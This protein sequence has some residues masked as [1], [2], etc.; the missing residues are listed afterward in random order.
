MP[1]KPTT[2]VNP[3]ELKNLS[4]D[5]LQQLAG[6][7]RRFLIDSVSKTGGHIGAN[8]GTVE[9]TLALHYVFDSPRDKLI[10]D[11][12][13]QGYTHKV[14]SGRADLFSSLN[15]YGG[16]NRFVSRSESR[17]D[18]I[19]ASHAGT[20]LSVGMGLA[21]ANRLQKK[22]HYVIPIIGD[23]ALCEGMALEA[24][25]HLGA[26]RDL[27]LIVLLNDNGFAISPGY[28]AL[29]DYLQSRQLNSRDPETLFTSLGFHYIGPVDGHDL[30]T[31]V[32]ALQQARD[33][34]RVP[35]VHAKTVKGK[36]LEAADSHPYRM[37]F[38]FP[39]DPQTG[40]AMESSGSSSVGY[41][42]VASAVIER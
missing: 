27:K 22:D 36:G 4:L 35:L 33:S 39:F 34:H 7:V 37:H 1:D 23:G 17:H 12:G 31:L 16:M 6:E 38:S 29:H 11:T 42:D 14:V 20:S 3:Q 5:E 15:T 24:L 9:L 18:I 32:Q 28:G 21:L 8:L 13:H 41:Q 40:Q 26:E 30:E 10:W 2:F 25:N 19:E